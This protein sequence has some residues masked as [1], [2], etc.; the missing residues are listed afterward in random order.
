M[1]QTRDAASGGFNFVADDGDREDSAVTRVLS[2]SNNAMSVGGYDDGLGPLPTLRSSGVSD[3]DESNA[4]AVLPMT[5]P[6]VVLLTPPAPAPS[7]L[8][9]IAIGGSG[10]PT[11]SAL[12]PLPAPPSVPPPPEASG[13]EW[14]SKVLWFGVG[15]LAFVIC[16]LLYL[17]FF[18]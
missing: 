9:M 16:G 18:R 2:T 10:N 12:S 4:T 5:A 11:M 6:A 3:P 17:I 8:P 13:G 15:G 1:V 14:L 7:P